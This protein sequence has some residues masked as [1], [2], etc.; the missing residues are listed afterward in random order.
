MA[1]RLGIDLKKVHGTGPSGRILIDDLARC[2][3]R[4]EP[5]TAPISPDVTPPPF[6]P[7]TR[8]KFLG[9]RRKIADRMVHAKQTIPHYTYVDECDVTELVRLRE[10]LKSSFADAGI[11][12]TYLPYIVKAAVA[13]LKEVPLV[14]ATLD[15]A[16]G[17]I[18]LHDHYHLGI[19]TDTPNGLVVP[20]VR[21][22]DQKS[23]VHLAR[24]ISRLTAEARAGKAK[25]DDLRGSTFTIT[26]I[27]N[28]GGLISTPIINPPEVGI[29]G[30][31]K[32][33]KRPVFDE[34]ENIRA[35]QMVYLSFSFDHRVVDG[36]VGAAFSNAI[37]RGLQNPATLMLEPF[38][39]SD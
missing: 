24:E 1:Q 36:A 19:A 39:P 2:V 31:G 21:D 16:A 23:L 15:E 5:H 17:E 6:Q 3:E 8:A 30:V 32:I 20:V 27:G 34:A 12:L 14:N 11:K 33:V 7:G 29:L 35:A 22:A 18:V 37:M 38:L 13:A 10:Q 25:S 4:T 9:L 26:S 28:I